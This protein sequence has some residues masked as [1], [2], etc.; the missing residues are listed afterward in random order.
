M[1]TSSVIYLLYG[2]SSVTTD[3]SNT[4]AVWSNGFLG[5]YHFGVNNIYL[6][7]VGNANITAYTSGGLS[8]GSPGTAGVGGQQVAFSS[9][10]KQY[11]ATAAISAFA[12]AQITM[13]CWANVTTGFSG[14]NKWF[15]GA[16][17]A[18]GN[19]TG[20]YIRNFNT[21]V[22]ELIQAVSGDTGRRSTSNLLANNTWAYMAL[23]ATNA[24]P[25][26]GAY[27]E[28]G[29]SMTGTNPFG[30]T[31]GSLGG[32]GN[33]LLWIGN[34]YGLLSADDFPLNGYMSEVRYSSV[35]RSADWITASYNN[36]SAPAS[37]YTVT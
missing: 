22:D 13:E 31:S 25:P 9:A 8:Q 36:Q 20:A 26:V 17:T 27:Y 35:V 14:N 15:F 30:S 28:G 11:A 34:L 3:Q 18:S 6:D 7:S 2:N 33:V 21:Q 19:N 32:S 37:F 23:S 24:N 1:Q 10:A 12:S 16:T 4:T 29:A 5:V